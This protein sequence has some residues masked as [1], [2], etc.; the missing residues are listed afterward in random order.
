MATSCPSTLTTSNVSTDPLSDNTTSHSSQSL[1]SKACW[2]LVKK[3]TL[4]EVQ[5]GQLYIN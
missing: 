5:Q 3:S 4:L 1:T 2:P